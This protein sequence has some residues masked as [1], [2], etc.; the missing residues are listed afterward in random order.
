[1]TFLSCLTKDTEL[2]LD[3]SVIINLLATEHA[4]P[5]LKALEVPIVVTGNVV[6][7]IERGAVNGRPE[8]ELLTAMVN[9]GIVRVEEL[10]GEVL[11]TLFD[12]VSGGTEESL[13]DG[14]AATLAFAYGSG[15]YAAIDEKKA[16]RLAAVRFESLRL[17]TTID[18]L[19]HESV[20]TLLGD[21]LLADATFRALRLARMQVREHQFEWVAELI[22]PEN[23][24][25]CSSLR[26]LAKRRATIHHLQNV[27]ERTA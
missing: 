22:G 18:I 12:L 7:E 9:E 25:A 3:T 10:G 2:V 21:E 16:T 27:N 20:R 4:V 19:A 14:E 5:I 23:V 24:D 11:A 8:F 15:F 13:D 1:M 17:V 6:R 26:R